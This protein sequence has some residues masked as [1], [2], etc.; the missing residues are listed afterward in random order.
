[1]GWVGLGVG[2]VCVCVMGRVR[3]RVILCVCVC[4]CVMGRVSV[5]EYN[6]QFVQYKTHYVYVMSLLR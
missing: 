5:K 4:V 3:G 1:M 6:I 2:L